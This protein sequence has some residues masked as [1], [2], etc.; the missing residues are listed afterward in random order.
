TRVANLPLFTID[1]DAFAKRLQ[2]TLACSAGRVDEPQYAN[3]D[4]IQAQGSHEVAVSKI[5]TETYAI[6]KRYIKGY[7]E[8]KPPKK[9]K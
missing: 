4:V 2:L 5:L 8:E 9:R 3:M 1:S 7:V 6:P